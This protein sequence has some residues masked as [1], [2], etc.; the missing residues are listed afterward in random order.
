MVVGEWGDGIIQ[1][2]FLFPASGTV[3]GI[4]EGDR[5]RRCFSARECLSKCQ[6]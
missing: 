4:L 1:G 2:V 3:V 6:L 5:I